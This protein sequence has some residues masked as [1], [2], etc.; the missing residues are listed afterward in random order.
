MMKAKLAQNEIHGVIVNKQDSFS[1]FI[2]DIELFVKRDDVLKALQIIN[3][4]VSE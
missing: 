4:S 2:G 3:K 1:K